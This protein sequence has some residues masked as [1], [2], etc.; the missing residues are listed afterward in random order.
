MKCN[1]RKFVEGWKKWRKTICFHGKEGGKCLEALPTP[2]CIIFCQRPFSPRSFFP[3]LFIR[4]MCYSNLCLHLLP[5]ES[6]EQ[7]GL[8]EMTR[9][10]VTGDERRKKPARKT[11]VCLGVVS[12]EISNNYRP[13]EWIKWNPTWCTRSFDKLCTF[14]PMPIP[15][16]VSISFYSLTG[17]KSLQTYTYICMLTNPQSMSYTFFCIHQWCKVR[18]IMGRG[19]LQWKIR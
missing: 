1:K 10:I 17:Y 9:D 15:T 8:R 13:A 14:S 11:L 4:S 6:P 16:I 12:S 3:R 5:R 2:F 19:V 7:E 18:R